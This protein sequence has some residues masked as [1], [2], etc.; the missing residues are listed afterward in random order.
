ME[1]PKLEK[2]AENPWALIAFGALAGVWLGSHGSR[3]EDAEPRGIVM[4][5]IGAFALKLVRDAALGQMTKIASQWLDIDLGKDDG[6][7][8]PATAQAQAQ[9]Q[10]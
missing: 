8:K 5:I 4:G 9:A 3:R 1:M 7:A 2:L 6:E 10:A